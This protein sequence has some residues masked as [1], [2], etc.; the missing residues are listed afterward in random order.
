MTNS[1]IVSMVGFAIGDEE[2]CLDILKVQEIIRLVEITRIPKSPDY[3][4][5]VINLRG[6]VI[7]I[8]DF[9]KRCGIFGDTEL[10]QQHKR[11]VV[12]SVGE[13]TIGLI[14]DK[15]SQVRKLVQNEITCTPSAVKGFNSDFISGVGKDGEKLLIILN[16]E[17]LITQGELAGLEQAA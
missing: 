8:F 13:R 3:V 6:N 14:V 10:E 16:L 12:T 7:P 1:E 4:E 17:E 2:F 5:G 11:I 9:R 15:V